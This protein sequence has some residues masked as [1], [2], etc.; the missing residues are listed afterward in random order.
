[1]RL[2]GRYNP[3]P[4]EPTHSFI[5]SFTLSLL[6]PTSSF[7]TSP[8]YLCVMFPW[9]GCRGCRNEAPP[10]T[11]LRAQS[12]QRNPF[13]KPGLGQNRAVRVLLLTGSTPFLP[14]PPSGSFTFIYFP[15]FF[16]FQHTKKSRV[17]RTLIQTSSCDLSY[18]VSSRFSWLAGRHI[19]SLCMPLYVFSYKVSCYQRGCPCQDP[20]GNRATRRPPDCRETDAN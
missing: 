9:W 3:A 14:S 17:S 19:S 4:D 8:L 11:R 15:T 16:L 13:L 12:F 7:S 2:T 10:P 1:M 5:Q 6:L 20:A 18:C